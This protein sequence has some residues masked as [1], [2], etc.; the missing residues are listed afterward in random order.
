[1][2]TVFQEKAEQLFHTVVTD[3]RWDL[4][5]ETLFNVFGLT[6]YGYCFGVGRL[7]CFLDIETI[8]GFVAGKLTGMG[9]GQKYVDG[10][11]DY[12]Y[13]TFTQPAEGLY[14]QLV[15]IGHAHFS[16]EDRALLTN[17]IFE[18]TARVK[19]G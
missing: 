19:Q 17:I 15:G 3:P 18:N 6:Y 7:L 10:L 4:Q 8:N 9:A 2:E 11:V 13:S 12:A 14:A 5:D 16:S 1:M